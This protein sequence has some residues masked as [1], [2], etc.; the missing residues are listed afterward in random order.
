MENIVVMDCKSTGTNY[1]SDIIN[2]WYNPIVLELKSGGHELDKYKEIMNKQ[3]DK[4][5]ADFDMIYERDT[6][7]ETLEAVRKYDPLLVLPGNEHGVILATKL[8]NDLNLL[9]NPIENIDAMTLKNEMHNR[10][11]EKGLRYIRGKVVSS[12]EEAI[13]F[14]DLESL[15][16]VVIKPIY[17]AGSA[18]VRIC[19]N[20][21]EMIESI[22]EILGKENYYGGKIKELIVQERINGTEYIVNTSHKGVHRITTI[23]KYRKIQTSDGEMIC[24]TAET[25]NELGIGEAEMVEYAYAV[26]DAIGIQYGPVHGEYMIDEKGP[27]LIEVNCRPSG[28]DLPAQYVDMIS[29]QHETDSSLDSYLKPNRFK[30]KRKEK[31]RLNAY[32]ALKLF[33]VPDDIIARSSPMKNISAKLKSYY[34]FE[35]DLPEED[36]FFMKT[37]DLH[38]SC[39]IAYLVHKD[40]S[41]LQND[42]EYLRS[43]E[44][45]A[46]NLVLSEEKVSDY[47][48]DEEKLISYL[49]KLIEAT[50]DYGTGLL[51][52][53]QILDDVRIRQV[54][55][56]ELDSV[57]SQFDYVILNLNQKLIEE[58]DD[59]NVYTILNIFSNIKV[60]EVVF[61]PESSYQYFS[62]GRKGIEVLLKTLDLTIEVPPHGFNNGIIA[63]RQY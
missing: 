9:C 23:W 24:D 45:H 28:P 40:K 25:V 11:R 32:G 55:P 57:N 29:G 44:K 35:L 6:Y 63:S 3:Y 12:A 38:S 5:D 1:I 51:I 34:K 16:E 26:A 36:T 48:L 33:I 50:D 62:S 47:Q 42:V 22:H 52:T 61:I 27:V 19:L 15:K 17:S 59:R 53:D 20:K 8:A 54:S 4:I 39:G 18:G 49:K 43:V 58:S 31:Y 10:L 2:R 37:E 30:E 21:D 46:F 60:G 56:D 13:E 7:E 14:Y 41:A